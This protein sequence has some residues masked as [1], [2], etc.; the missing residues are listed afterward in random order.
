MTRMGNCFDL[1]GEVV[2]L[3]LG[4]ESQSTGRPRR[5]SRISRKQSSL[6]KTDFMNIYEGHLACETLFLLATQRWIQ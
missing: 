4:M 6:R 3:P 1:L 2:I 5:E